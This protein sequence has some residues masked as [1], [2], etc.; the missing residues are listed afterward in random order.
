MDRFG[1]NMVP[2]AKS[3]NETSKYTNASTNQ[4]HTNTT[5]H[6]HNTEQAN[7]Q[8]PALIK[9]KHIKQHNI[10]TRNTQINEMPARMKTIK[11]N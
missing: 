6:N 10:R 9:H 2:L 5:A 8:I 1:S 11:T 7:Q 3:E 4:K